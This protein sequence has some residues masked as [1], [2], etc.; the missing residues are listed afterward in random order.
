MGIEADLVIAQ[1]AQESEGT[2]SALGMGWQVR[3][4]EPIPWALVIIIRATRDLIGRTY[5][6]IR[7]PDDTPLHADLADLLRFDFPIVPEGMTDAN[8]VSAVVRG[9]AFNLLPVPLEPGVEY[10]FRL[11]VEGETQPLDGQLSYDSSVMET[12]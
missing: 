3:P 9:Y 10:C 2:V 8:L 11:W 5:P 6:G 12:A 1:S 7:R 4:P